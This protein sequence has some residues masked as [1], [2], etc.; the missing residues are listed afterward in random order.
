[1]LE[2][3]LVVLFDSTDFWDKGPE[4]IPPPI[5]AAESKGTTKAVPGNGAP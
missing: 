1:M 5:I 3:A 2:A 4:W